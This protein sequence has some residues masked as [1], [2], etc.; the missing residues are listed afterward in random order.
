MKRSE[1]AALWTA[2]AV[3]VVGVF[4]LMVY[5]QSNFIT[6]REKESIEQRL[7]RIENKIDRMME[8]TG[9][10]FSNDETENS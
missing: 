3:G 6:I 1:L 8:D 9:V 5:A 10:G 7:E 2:F 4:S